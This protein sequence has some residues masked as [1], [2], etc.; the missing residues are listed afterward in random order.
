MR[1]LWPVL[2]LSALLI[3]FSVG[4]RCGLDAHAPAYTPVPYQ[5]AAL[6][7]DLERARLRADMLAVVAAEKWVTTTGKVCRCGLCGGQWQAGKKAN[8]GER[9]VLSVP[10][11]RKR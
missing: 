8:H 2:T 3:V 4:Y 1:F 6:T 9:C 10:E 7:V 11:W 5:V